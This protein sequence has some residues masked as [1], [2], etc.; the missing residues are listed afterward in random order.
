MSQKFS[1]TMAGVSLNNND[2][3]IIHLPP[4]KPINLFSSPS[5][6]EI[7]RVSPRYRYRNY[8]YYTGRKKYKIDKNSPH[9]RP[10]SH[11]FRLL[12]MENEFLAG[13]NEHKFFRG[14]LR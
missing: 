3:T 5:H 10:S 8:K 6:Y 4:E 2:I 13:I 1:T 9:C 14:Q 11:N 12:K 7:Q